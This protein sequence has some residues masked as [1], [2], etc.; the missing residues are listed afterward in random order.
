MEEKTPLESV[1]ESSW[2]LR[3]SNTIWWLLAFATVI[4]LGLGL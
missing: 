3:H 1:M 2:L 4:V